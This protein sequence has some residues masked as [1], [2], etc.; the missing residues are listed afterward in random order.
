MIKLYKDDQSRINLIVADT[1]EGFSQEIDWENFNTLGLRLIK[2]LTEQIN[3]N[4]KTD[5]SPEKGTSF[6]IDFC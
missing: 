1:G 5:I 6:H 3:G 4:L 2:I